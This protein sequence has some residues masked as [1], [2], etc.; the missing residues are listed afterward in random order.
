MKRMLKIV[1]LIVLAGIP[2]SLMA[3]GQAAGGD[4]RLIMWTFVDLHARFYESMMNQW[5]KEHPDKQLKITFTNMPYGEMHNKVTMAIQTGKG[6]PDL[7]DIEIGQFPNYLKGTV[8]FMELDKYLV[9]Y[10]KNTVKSRLEIYGK[11]GHYYGVPTHVGAMVMYYNTELLESA[12]IDYRTIVTWDDFTAAGKKYRA[13]T[14]KSLTTVDTGGTDWFAL[15]MS[16]YGEDWIDAT[17]R[18]NIKIPAVRKMLEMQAQ[19]IKDGVAEVSPGGIVDTEAGFANITGGGLAAFPKA[20]WF[21]SRFINYMPEMK[22]KWALA[23]C[24][25]FTKGQPRSVGVGG[26]GTVVYAGSPKADIAAEFMAW[27]KLSYEGNVQIW[28]QLGFDPCNTDMWTDKKVTHDAKNQYVAYFKT[29]PFDILNQIKNE[30][31]FVKVTTI[32]PLIAEQFNINVLFDVL[33][34][35]GDITAALNEAQSQID[36]EQ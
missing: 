9:P 28:Q 17:G 20:L 4:E 18:A 5:N 27:A 32:S 15:A 16:E 31:G 29:N 13:V 14:G 3:G 35:G 19:W 8:P 11:D 2:A 10:E 26:T 24:P 6:V 30:I 36:L 34:D 7:C 33:Q 1:L 12:G 22:G 23:P 21:M 25:V